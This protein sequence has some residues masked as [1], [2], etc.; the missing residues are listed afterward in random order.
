MPNSFANRRGLKGSKKK[1]K[2]Q[3]NLL[4]EDFRLK[5]RKSLSIWF[6]ENR[7]GTYLIILK[8]IILHTICVALFQLVG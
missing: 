7:T 6:L 3:S 2:R 8:E 5:N 4:F 1:S